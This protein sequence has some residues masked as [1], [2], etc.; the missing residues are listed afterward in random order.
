MLPGIDDLKLG[1]RYE[2]PNRAAGASGQPKGIGHT[3]SLFSED[4]ILGDWKTT[5]G[6]AYLLPQ[7]GSI[8]PILC[9]CCPKMVKSSLF[10]VLT[11]KLCSV[12]S[13]D[14][15]KKTQRIRHIGKND[16]IDRFLFTVFN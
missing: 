7:N 2:I 15:L 8:K 14:V 6:F 1:D 5:F 16:T 13:G 9:I 11:T 3:V 4:R 12:R 10:C